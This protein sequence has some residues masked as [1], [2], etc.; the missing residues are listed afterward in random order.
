[1][2]KEQ[3]P[4]CKIVLLTIFDSPEFQKIIKPDK[5]I[6]AVLGKNDLFE[7]LAPLIKKYLRVI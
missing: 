5:I 6:N 7:K 1:M 4:D 3:L 2:I